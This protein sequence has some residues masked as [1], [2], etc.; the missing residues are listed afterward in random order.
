MRKPNIQ[1]LT[2][3]GLLLASTGLIPVQAA[4]AADSAEPEAAAVTP[5]QTELGPLELTQEAARRIIADIQ[6]NRTLYETDSE[7]LYRMVDELLLTAFDFETMSLLVLGPNWK[8]ASDEQKA[9][10]VSSFKG[11]L[12]RTYSKALLQAGD[13]EIVWAPLDLAPNDSRTVVSAKVPTI[14]GP[15]EMNWRLRKREEGWRVYDIVVDGISLV[16]NY[17]GTYN[18][19]I[20]KIGLDGLIEKLERSQG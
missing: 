16:T 13:T 7:A 5:A 12:I 3:A 11:L 9:R 10:F 4:V 15:I 8:S 18:A 14:S 19:E 2:L 6:E 17:R 20:R 1:T